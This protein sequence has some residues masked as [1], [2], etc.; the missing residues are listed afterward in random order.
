VS[1]ANLTIRE[2]AER[3]GIGQPTLRMWEQRFGFPVP[4]R[5]PSGHRR[6]SESD[7]DHLMQVDGARRSGMSLSGAI[8]RARDAASEAGA[9]IYA[10]LRRRRP[11]LDPFLLPKRSLIAMS[12]AIEDECAARAERPLLFGSFQRERFYRMAERR[13]RELARTA[14]LA[15]VF[16]DFAEKRTPEGG[17]A[18]LPI[19]RSDP[20]GREW[21]LICEARDYSAC[22]AAWEPPGQDATPDL[23]RTFETI[24]CVEAD[25]VRDAV[26]LAVGLARR[27]GP[28]L[29]ERFDERLESPPP[30][31]RDEMRLVSDLTSRM[32]AYVGA[33]PVSPFP[34]PRRSAEA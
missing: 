34:A 18:E 9:S 3:T 27:S 8:D 25:V 15:V 19:D 29:V 4:R 7:V 31:N 13:W 5:L 26:R 16:A 12:H 17:P 20:F 11:E 24:W 2:V 23:D 14:D 22:L 33:G 28:E 30:K 1:E 21:S 10:G 32:V 6:Y